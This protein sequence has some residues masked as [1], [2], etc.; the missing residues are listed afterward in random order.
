VPAA[1]GIGTPSG[2]FS[3]SNIGQGVNT[4][5]DP[6]TAR[7]LSGGSRVVVTTR[8]PCSLF[9]G[10]RVDLLW[11]A[12]GLGFEPTHVHL[13]S[14]SLSS[15]VLTL[16]PNA[17]VVTS[18]TPSWAQALPAVAFVHGNAHTFP[19]LFGQAEAIFC[20]KVRKRQ[21]HCP[22][23]GWHL[24]HTESSHAGVGGVTDGFEHCTGWIRAVTEIP[25]I[26]RI[27]TP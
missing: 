22:P 15:V 10:S 27:P 18:S 17:N 13:L 4:S 20:T 9:L 12:L 25:A 14:G 11:T 8:E 26:S 7:G 16:A 23:P 3:D 24:V 1:I 2:I 21:M 19:F 5:D 6:L